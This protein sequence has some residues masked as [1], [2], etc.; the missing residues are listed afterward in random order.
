MNRRW[1]LK[2]SPDELSDETIEKV[3]EEE[4]SGDKKSYYYPFADYHRR[5]Q[6]G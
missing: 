3:V 2:Y 5:S 4:N 1:G 6:A